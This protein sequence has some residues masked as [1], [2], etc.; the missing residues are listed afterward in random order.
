M[1]K[2]P[3]DAEKWFRVT[4][5]EAVQG[6]IPLVKHAEH[7]CYTY[8]QA[9]DLAHQYEA[10]MPTYAKMGWY[11]YE[12]RIVD[13]LFRGEEYATGKIFEEEK[14]NENEDHQD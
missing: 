9:L 6:V 4:L 12:V 11:G 13:M 3:G 8:P 1:A 7:W 5:Y 10:M 14:E 2:F